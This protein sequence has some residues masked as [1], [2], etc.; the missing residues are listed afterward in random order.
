MNGAQAA[1]QGL[2]GV[3]SPE[4][5]GDPGRHGC[6][7]RPVHTPGSVRARGQHGNLAPALT[8]L[9]WVKGQIHIFFF[10]LILGRET[11]M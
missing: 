2:K 7:C 5:A 10:F 4:T 8:G 1:L 6:P 9:L 11:S 3:P